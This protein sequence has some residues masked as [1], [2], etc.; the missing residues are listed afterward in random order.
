ME[1]TLSK[2]ID[3]NT[4]AIGVLDEHFNDL[5]Q[6]IYGEKLE[7][8]KDTIHR[9]SEALRILNHSWLN[10]RSYLN[11]IDDARHQV[12]LLASVCEKL[13][14]ENSKLKRELTNL[15]AGI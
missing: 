4:Y 5:L 10:E 11:H 12:K 15:K 1:N 2:P 14:T 7:E 8:H 6:K 3:P 13:K 9:I